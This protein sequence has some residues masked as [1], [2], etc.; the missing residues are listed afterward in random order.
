MI[1]TVQPSIQPRRFHS[2]YASGVS[3]YKRERS[4]GRW[5]LIVNLPRDPV[6]GR[7]RQKS[8]TVYGGSRKADQ[9]LRKLLDEAQAGRHGDAE[10]TLSALIAVWLDQVEADLSPTTRQEYRRLAEGRIAN[11]MG[12]MPLRKV[13]SAELRGFYRARAFAPTDGRTF[14]WRYARNISANERRCASLSSSSA[15]MAVS[16][17]GASAA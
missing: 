9:E 14:A 15:S 4:K 5:E 12:K 3:G 11:Y 10:I 8:R 16:S 7:R 6:T 1:R 13:T 2:A 17:A